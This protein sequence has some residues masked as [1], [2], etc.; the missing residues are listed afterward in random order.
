MILIVVGIV[1]ALGIVALGGIGFYAFHK[2]RQ[3]GIDPDLMRRNPALATAKI[4]VKMNPDVELIKV[5]EDRGTII[6]RDK[7]TGKVMTASFENAKNGHFTVSA[8]DGSNIEFNGEKGSLEVKGPDGTAKFGGGAATDIPSWVPQ[9]PGSKPENAAS[10]NSAS[11]IGGVFH[12]KTNDTADSVMK[13]YSEHAK[14][15]GLTIT[16]TT[17]SQ[18]QKG[19]GGL[20]SAEDTATKR[21]LVVVFGNEGGENGVMVTYSTKK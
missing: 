8:N 15:A 18:G 19:A 4:A 20:L 7:K 6:V 2:L 13:F 17:S 9:Y 10:S 3:A 11:E 21:S 16:N 5:D 14:S 1:L 12:F